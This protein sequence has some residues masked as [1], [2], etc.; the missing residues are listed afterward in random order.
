MPKAHVLQS[1]NAVNLA[2][3]STSEDWQQWT[4]Y[5]T[6]ETWSTVQHTWTCRMTVVTM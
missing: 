2:A 4:T 5:H 6:D 1:P 3:C